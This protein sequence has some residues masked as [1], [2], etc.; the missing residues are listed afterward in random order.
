MKTLEIKENA[1]GTRKVRIQFDGEYNSYSVTRIINTDHVLERKN[2]KKLNS[3][4]K[5]A[6]KHINV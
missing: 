3:A 4:V 5:Y 1:S 2:F 6:E